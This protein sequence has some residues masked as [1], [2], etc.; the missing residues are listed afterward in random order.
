MGSI[1]GVIR[2]VVTAMTVDVWA[3]GLVQLLH[4]FT[5]GSVYLGAM[6]F[7]KQA[8][9]EELASTAQALFSA[10]AMGL[11]MAL[12]L[13]LSGYAFEQWA[14]QSYFLMA[15]LSFLGGIGAL[16]LGRRW[17]GERLKISSHS[18]SS[19]SQSISGS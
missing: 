16:V 19:K 14:G 12:A 9:P 10:I 7:L 8:A 1:A 15:G 6:E 17:N 3:L 2:W 18:S 13:P 5:F 11:A 4:A